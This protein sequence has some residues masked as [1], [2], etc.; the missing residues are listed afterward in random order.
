MAAWPRASRRWVLPVP[1]GPHTTRFSCRSIHSRVASDRCVGAGTELT[2]SSQVS[3]VLPVGNP[4]AARLV[5]IGARPVGKGDHEA[6][7]ASEVERAH[8]C[9]IGAARDPEP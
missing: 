5:M 2:C 4:A 7:V 9:F 6:V 8:R 3:N 1:E